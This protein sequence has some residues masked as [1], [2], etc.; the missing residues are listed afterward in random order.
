MSGLSTLAQRLRNIINPNIVR[1]FLNTEEDELIRKEEMDRLNRVCINTLL[2][3]CYVTY[4]R[5]CLYNANYDK[6]RG[7]ANVF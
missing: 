6:G 4:R 1:Y 5:G 7:V 3:I 2:Q